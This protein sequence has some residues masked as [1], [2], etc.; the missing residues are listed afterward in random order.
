LDLLQPALAFSHGP[1]D[2]HPDHDIMGREVRQVFRY[3]L[4]LLFYPID[5]PVAEDWFRP[6]LFLDAEPYLERTLKVLAECF[7]T[8]RAKMY[9]DPETQRS[10]R[11]KWGQQAGL[12][13]AEAFALERAILTSQPWQQKPQNGGKVEIKVVESEERSVGT[14]YLSGERWMELRLE[15]V[16]LIRADQWQAQAQPQTFKLA[17]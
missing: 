10:T 12:E 6:T 4:A 15:S 11:R 9:C 3:L 16:G 13:Y 7:P 8:E 1:G 2:T 14:L 5:K 17:A